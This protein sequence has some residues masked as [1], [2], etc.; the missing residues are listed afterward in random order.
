MKVKDNERLSFRVADKS[1]WL[2]WHWSVK[3]RDS[4]EVQY[5][6]N[7]REESYCRP[8]QVCFLST[9]N[10][11]TVTNESI[12]TV[13]K[14]SANAIRCTASGV[15]AGILFAH[16]HRSTNLFQCWQTGRHDCHPCRCSSRCCWYRC[17]RNGGGGG[18]CRRCRHR[19]GRRW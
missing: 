19:C 14:K 16:I 6:L 8:A 15:Q 4:S 17:C 10:F 5:P 13:T 1:Q 7:E 3:T 11:A 12:Q 9:S 2:N 18:S